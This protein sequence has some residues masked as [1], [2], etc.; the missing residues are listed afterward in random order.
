M[1]DNYIEKRMAELRD[2]S[3]STMRSSGPSLDELLV[4]N[5]SCRG[6]DPSYRVHRLQLEAMVRV[7]T[8]LA[9][10]RNA[11]TLRFKMV[12]ASTPGREL[13]S[14]IRIG[15][16]LPELSLPLPGT[17]AQAFIVVCSTVPENPIVDIDLGIS[18]EA[19]GLK[20]AQM[21]LNVL[22]IRAFDKAAVRRVLGLELDPL[23]VLAVGRGIEKFSLETVHACDNL[24]YYR[25]DGVHII[26]KL[27]FEDILL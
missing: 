20:A 11:Q 13:L 15:G 18:M 25:Q 7:N 23:A 21:G 9:S 8:R 1:A 24:N 27:A 14:S 19:M 5:R 26:P 2:G 12:E 16:A 3:S 17:E 6:F 10:G 4:R 22:I